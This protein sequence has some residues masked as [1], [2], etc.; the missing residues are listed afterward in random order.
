[1]TAEVDID[2]TVVSRRA[3]ADGV[4]SLVLASQTE[5]ELPPWRP[6]AHIDLIVAPGTVRQYS[7]TG[8]PDNRREWEIA[9]Q[10]EAGGRGGS[11]AVFDTVWPGSTV[12]IHGPRNHFELQPADRYL[13]IA[14]GIGITPIRAMAHFAST[15]GVDWR[16]LYGG[17]TAASMAY[18]GELVDRFGMRQVVLRPQDTFGLL[19]LAGFL[20]HAT[21]DTLV[22][23]CGPEP[24]LAAAEKICADLGLR[25]HVERFSPKPLQQGEADQEFDVELTRSGVTVHVPVGVSILSVAERAGALTTS[26]CEE[27]TCGSCQ[28]TVLDGTPVHRDSVLSAQERAQGDTMMI[29]VSR[30]RGRL[31]LDL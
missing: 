29:C 12:T 22:Y 7:L 21:G 4:I 25:L 2:V 8:S 30:A 10:L 19:D 17:R 11:R 6:G 20:Q 15:R 23:C 3:A 5:R 28:T 9:V 18:A 31:V 14:G 13:F 1:M 16:L 26:S 27:G 24:L